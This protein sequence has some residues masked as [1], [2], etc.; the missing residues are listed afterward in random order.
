LTTPRLGGREQELVD[1][2]TVQVVTK[3]DPEGA[4]IARR[5]VC[6]LLYEAFR[7]VAPAA[8]VICGHQSTP[9]VMWLMSC[10]REKPRASSRPRRPVA[11]SRPSAWA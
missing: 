5:S 11:K 2:A 3:D 10:Q 1:G 8:R 7:R 4:R 6:L 9:P